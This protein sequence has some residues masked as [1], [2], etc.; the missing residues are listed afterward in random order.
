MIRA[1]FHANYDDYRPV[2]W[3]VKHPYWC[4]GYG[5]D[6]SIIVTYA[7]DI[8]EIKLNW[9]EASNIEA[10]E[11]D[12]YK[13]SSRFPKPGWFS[14]DGGQEDVKPKGP[15]FCSSC[16]MSYDSIPEKCGVNSPGCD[17]LLKQGK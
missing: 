1:R 8:E 7:D 9:P 11:V 15:W 12:T 5:N 2:V 13:F 14:F 6:Y 3:P 4:S 10:E 16:C 17:D